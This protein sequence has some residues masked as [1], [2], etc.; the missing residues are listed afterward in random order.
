MKN[1]QRSATGRSY[2]IMSKGEEKIAKLLKQAQIDYERE[3][4]FQD[5]RHKK[6]R[7]DFYLPVQNIIIEF[8]G[9]QHYQ[10]TSY[11]YRSQTDFKAA[12]ERDR[13]KISYALANHKPIY[14]IPYYDLDKITCAADLFN[15][16]Y[17]AKS[18]WHVDD[19]RRRHNWL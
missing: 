9:Q 1:P 6:Y 3:R 19:D 8:H 18:R 17:L 16:L 2:T 14:I 12:C 4:S 11:F 15:P 7:Y 5:L 13:K 10:Y